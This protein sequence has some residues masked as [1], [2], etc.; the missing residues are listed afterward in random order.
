VFI[1]EKSTSEYLLYIYVK[2]N[3][4]KQRIIPNY[5]ESNYLTVLVRSKAIQNKA[6][7]ELINLL[8]NKLMVST[9]QIQIISGIR[10]NNKII[11]IN[12]INRMSKNEI[13]KRLNS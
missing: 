13:I 4:K 3:S 6:N 2:P 10:N 5:E 1:K 8:K 9:N 11:Q 12:F 7:K